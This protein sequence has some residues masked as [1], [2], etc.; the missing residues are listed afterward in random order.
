MKTDTPQP[1]HL[2]DY[3]PVPYLIDSVDLDFRLDPQDTVVRSRLTLRP[4][5]AR[6]DRGAALVLDGERITLQSLALDGTVLQPGQYRVEAQSLTIMEVPQR[7]FTLE[8]VTRCNPSANTELSGL[9]VS[10][11]VFCTQCEAE[12]F[13]RI[14][15][16]HDRPDVMARYT[17]RI[18]AEREQ[19]P[20]LLSNG[21]PREDGVIGGTT[22]HYAVWD[23]PFPKPSYLFAL[24]AGDLGSVH[25]TFTTASGR[26]VALG[27]YVLKGKEDRCAWA[28]DSL[29]AS[30]RWDEQRFGREYDLDV[31][32]I[33]AVP[34]FNMGAMENKG[35]NVFNDKYI[36]AN[37]ETA[38]DA[39]YVNIEAIIA[40]EYFHNWTGNRITCRD[41]FQLCL[42]EGLTVFRD[43]EFT[44][45]LRSRAVKRIADVKTLRARQFPEDNGPLAHPPRP[46]AYIEINN[47]YTPTVYEKGAEI[48]RM[49]LTLIGEQAFRKAMDLYFE[50]HDGEAATVE[51][52]V[53]CM[54]E[55]SGRNLAQFFTWY[56][57]AGTPTLTAEGQY[58]AAT[59]QYTLTLEQKVKPTPGQAEKQPLHIPLG[60]GL[61][62]P[63]GADMPLDLDGV[64]TLNT[65]LIE[66]TEQ[67][68]SFRFN[69]VAKRPVLS[70]NRGFSAPVMLEAN[71]PTADELFLMGHDSDSFNRWEAGQRL[72][73]NL[74]LAAYRGTATAADVSAYAAALKK[75]IDDAATDDAF[76]ALML[77]LPSESEIAA[78]IGADVDT[79]KVHA[80]RDGLRRAIARQLAKELDDIWV[81]TAEP[82]PYRPDPASTARRALRQ[83]ALALMV[84]GNP[85]H[86]I[87]AALAEFDAAHNMSAEIGALGALVQI[88]CPEREA[89]LDQFHARHAHEHLLVDKWLLLN[90]QAQGPDAA[91]RITRLTQ[92]PD[93]KWT[94]PNKVYALLSGFVG[95]NPAGFNAEDG[96]GFR[97]IADAILKIDPV[98]PQVASRLATGFRS[99]KLLNSSRKSA[100]QAELE[101]ILAEPSLSRDVFEIVSKIAAS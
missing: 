72:G 97:V 7:A 75:I 10:G 85:A 37:P 18:E 29:K 80:A 16:F 36:L 79:D 76:K 84:M 91:A 77:L 27:I 20:V 46:A 56:T 8:M 9:Y 74:V 33:V 89:A 65:P 86:G 23:D 88:D 28:M 66:M 41:W 71:L 69:N 68:Q 59:R 54:A 83:T 98:N 2:A 90:A 101:R 12:G 30:M 21:N 70:L 47:F 3:A 62:G 15:Y 4:N 96:S 100:A 99:C 52:F 26:D 32:N 51:Q 63:D 34:D 35:L 40:H 1:I 11:G 94:T 87:K 13:R 49:M 95:A 22:R 42:K 31:F 38:T 78:A 67:R 55:A 82:G 50:R 53:Q 43:Q 44:S 93:F 61:V 17:V 5:P 39:D 57:Q 48:C 45:D 92:H 64:G 24:V 81:R 14:T 25:D 73:R 19:V 6:S 60:I 58:D